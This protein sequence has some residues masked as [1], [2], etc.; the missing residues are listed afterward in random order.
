MSTRPRQL[1][2]ALSLGIAQAADSF[3]FDD[4]LHRFVLSPPACENPTGCRD[5]RNFYAARDYEPA[6][7]GDAPPYRAGLAIVDALRSSASHGLNPR[8]YAAD[9]LFK[10][11]EAL[12]PASSASTRATLDA[13]LTA[14]LLRAVRDV[15]YGRID[16]RTIHRNYVAPRSEL[17]LAQ[18]IQGDPARI[19]DA[20]APR[21]PMYEALRTVL[22]TYRGLSRNEPP[23]PQRPAQPVKR[24]MPYPDLAR[25]RDRLVALG[26]LDPK[27]AAPETFDNGIVDA[28]KHFQSRHGLAED[29]I[30]GAETWG[31]LQVPFDARARQIELALERL[32]WLPA[33]D[34]PRT[35]GVNIP[36]FRLW[37]LDQR[38]GNPQTR[39]RA[40]VVV[41]RAAATRTP[42]FITQIRAVELNPYWNVPASITRKEILPALRRDPRSLEREQMEIV[43]RTTPARVVSNLD[44]ETLDRLERGELRIRQRPGPKNALGQ[45]RFAMPNALDIYLHD[46]PAKALFE[47]SRRDFSH[48]CIRVEDP[49]RLAEFLLEDDPRWNADLLREAIARGTFSAIPLRQPVPVLLFYTT[50]VVD[51]DGR[52]VFLPDIYRYDAALDR[53]LYQLRTRPVSMWTKSDAG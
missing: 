24:G 28:V 18:V 42:V 15:H 14:S 51:P 46:T 1:C 48:G 22:Q 30:L 20:A 21:L 3:A 31:A 39:F 41:G 16:P 11:L 4:A 10:Q 50:V 25:L 19:L 34:A 12:S 49:L 29:G 47:R 9:R 44:S 6:W 35:I 40:N 7:I 38:G 43:S 13:A 37:A 52:V 32:R 33:I 27:V 36:E 17:D 53:A 5:L 26:D 23:V 8:D 45:I 2:L